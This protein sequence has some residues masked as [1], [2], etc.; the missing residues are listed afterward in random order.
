MVV[1][2]WGPDMVILRR[3]AD[4]FQKRDLRALHVLLQ[5]ISCVSEQGDLTPRA[6]LLRGRGG[7]LPHALPERRADG[8]E[9]FED[10][11][12]LRR[13]GDRL[14]C[15]EDGAARERRGSRRAR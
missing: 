8:E 1:E 10:R 12:A 9:L 7:A 6:R 4:A 13:R 14:R 11:G 3:V 2:H 15:E 5:E